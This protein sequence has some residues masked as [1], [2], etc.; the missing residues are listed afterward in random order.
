MTIKYQKSRVFAIAYLMVGVGLVV[1][2][3][4]FSIESSE[5][6]SSE[7]ESL[8]KIQETLDEMH[9][10]GRVDDSAYEVVSKLV[11]KC[12]SQSELLSYVPYGFTAMG[13]IGC[14]MLFFIWCYLWHK[15][16]SESSAQNIQ[17][18]TVTPITQRPPKKP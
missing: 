3:V 2:G 6:H 5:F 7:K 4:W 9:E 10:V 17:T 11:Y 13:V 16:L 14:I 12:S 8:I 18:Q 15:R 1:I